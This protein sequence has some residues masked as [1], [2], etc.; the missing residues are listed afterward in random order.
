MS[1]VDLDVFAFDYDLTFAVLLMHA[2][3]TVYHRF[4]GRDADDATTYATMPALARLLRDTL[5][6]HEA[7]E[8]QPDRALRAAQ[9]KPRYVVDLPPLA[10]RRAA[11]KTPS[12][13]H[14]HTVHDTLHQHAI[15]T[16]T[17]GVD[18]QFVY[19]SPRRVGLH[20]DP[21][22]Q[23]RVVEVAADSPAHRAG[24][25]AGDEL[26]RV[27]AQ[28]R[29]ATFTDV[30]WALH[31]AAPVAT[32]VPIAWRR[33]EERHEASLQLASGWKRAPVH[34]YAWRP[35][36]WNLAPDPGFG[37]PTLSAGEKQKLGLDPA[38]FA[39]RVQYLIDW[40]EKAPRGVAAREA[41]LRKGDIVLRYAGQTDFASTEHFQTWV[42]LTCRVGQ[43]VEI[44]VLRAGARVKLQMRLPE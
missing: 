14:C 41:G 18:A 23:A 21:Q 26:L 2:D 6:E 43:E 24:L 19:P 8:R 5:P 32:E 7:Y 16:D 44:E 31:V 35:Y 36:K 27:G 28:A 22:A 30:Q 34:D 4:G 11:A 1:A 9:G 3:G 38:S 42:R 39:L 40:G 29:V 17:L 15:E 10:R 13:V 12:C 33:G 25:R 37:G 20:L